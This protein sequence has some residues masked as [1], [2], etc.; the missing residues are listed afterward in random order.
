MKPVKRHMKFTE[1][2]VPGVFLIEPVVYEDERGF[3]FEWY[4]QATFAKHGIRTKFVQDNHSSSHKGVLRGLHYQMEPRAQAKLIRVVRGAVFDV[5]VDLRKGSKT[6]GQHVA[7]NLSEK[8][9]KILYVP[10]GFAHGFCAL[11]DDTEFLYKVS[12]FYSPKHE[13]GIRWNDPTLKIQW[14][15][16]DVHYVLTERDQNYP[17]FG[18][19]FR[20]L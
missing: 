11:A 10:E 2:D 9:K 3:F 6:F 4:H 14:P 20:R 18:D 8:N 13:R 5:A 12:T 17:S 1:L 7:M 16:L 19:A 15:E